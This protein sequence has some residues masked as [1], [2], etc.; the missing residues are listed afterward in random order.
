MEPEQP[1]F[2]IVFTGQL[3]EGT[4]SEEA[5]ANLAQLFKTT[6][7]KTAQYFTGKPKA[8]KRGVDKATAMKYK[9]ALHKA[10]LVVA[11]KAHSSTNIESTGPSTSAS[12]ASSTSADQATGNLG[13]LTIAPAGT[14][15]LS[16][17][18]RQPVVEADIDTSNIKMVSAFME[19]EPEI[20]AAPPAPNT[21]HISV[22][23]VGEDILEEQSPEAPELD[24]N[25]DDITLA[26]PGADLD[27]LQ[28]DV[29][30]LEPDISG[31]NL[32]ESGGEILSDGE[33]APAP[34]PAPDTSHIT[35]E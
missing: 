1:L 29:E 35:L 16:T 12:P 25:L 32:A 28:P 9:A 11:F 19:P 33:K 2:D 31:I 22:A 21:S 6:P 3:V 8:L 24:L 27:E 15:I 4:S 7:D 23:P 26:P 17:Q 10:G 18:E 20:K 30:L 34:P 14:Q 5:Q 13:S